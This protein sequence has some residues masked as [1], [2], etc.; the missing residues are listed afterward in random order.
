MIYFAQLFF[1]ALC[2]IHVMKTGQERYWIYVVVML[3]GIGILAYIIV[4]LVPS[5]LDT[6]QGYKLEK[7]LKNIINPR[8]ALA[9]AEN[10]VKD[11]PTF[12]NK[13][14]LADAYLNNGQYQDSLNLYGEIGQGMYQYDPHLLLHAAKCY[15]FLN[16]PQK[17][18]E[19]LDLL[20]EK[21]PDFDSSE[22]H[23]FYAKSLALAGNT[24][25]AKKEFE[26]LVKYYRGYEAKV[27]Y[28][29]ALITMKEFDRAKEILLD[30]RDEAKRAPKH[31]RELNGDSLSRMKRIIADQRW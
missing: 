13:S 5:L 9:R 16:A 12:E 20:R 6:K 31:V 10:D 11:A 28:G 25:R 21:N 8:A 26:S 1:M 3:P 18:I 22:G 23:L 27:S 24:I 7:N 15:Y 4:V 14:R 19:T 17:C 30:L 29:E 2:V